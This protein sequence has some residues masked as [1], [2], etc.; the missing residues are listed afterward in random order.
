MNDTAD[1]GA[2]SN[3]IRQYQALLAISNAIASHRDLNAVLRDLAERLRHVVHFDEVGIDLHDAVA[4]TMRVHALTSTVVTAQPSLRSYPVDELPAGWVWRSGKPLILLNLE[5]ESRWPRFLDTLRRRLPARSICFLPLK[6]PRSVLGTLGFVSRQASAYHSGELEFLGHVSNQLAVAVESILAFDEVRRLTKKVEHDQAY[7]HEEIST[8][9]SPDEIIGD[10]SALRRV[11]RDVDT[12]APT[13]ATVLIGGETGTGKELIARAIHLRS[14]RRDRTFVK[15]NCAA[16]P[17][18]LLESELF[19][20]EKGAFTGAVMQRFGRFELAHQGSLFLDEVADIP[21]ELQPKLLRVLQD[22]EFERLGST[23]T[24]RV[25]VR[26]MAATNCDLARM[27][28]DGAF[29]SDLYYRLH[30]FPVLLPPLRERRE[31]IPRLVWHFTQRFTRQMGKH[32]ET[33]PT[34]VMRALTAYDW[35]G[36]IRELENFIERAVILS[37]GSVLHVPLG[38]L[39]NGASLLAGPPASTEAPTAAADATLAA[40]E[41]QHILRALRDAH[42][43]LGGPRGAAMRLGMKRSTLQWKMKRLGIA[44]PQD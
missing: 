44:R 34:A 42:G 32:I 29:R 26:V 40:A 21:L 27:V 5:A 33:I 30:V 17:T 18:G 12:V 36:N 24:L 9:H 23:R 10:S 11:L 3:V 22:Q 25:N 16:I 20:H 31:D 4:N 28:R 8:E 14:T 41:R 6:T 37:T 13:A 2:P 38:E 19:G 7:L 43:V 15:F 1:N 39:M 35:P